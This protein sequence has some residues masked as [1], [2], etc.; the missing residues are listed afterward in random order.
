[1]SINTFTLHWH[2][3]IHL[4]ILLLLFFFWPNGMWDLS[5]LTGNW[6]PDPQQWNHRFLFRT[7]RE[8]PGSHWH[9]PHSRL[10]LPKYCYF[11]L[12]KRNYGT[13]QIQVWTLQTFPLWP[14]FTWWNSCRA[15]QLLA[16][17]LCRGATHSRHWAAAAG[18]SH[19]AAP[20]TS[21]SYLG[22]CQPELCRQ[23]EQDSAVR[24]AWPKISC[25]WKRQIN[26]TRMLYFSSVI[27]TSRILELFS[28]HGYILRKHTALDT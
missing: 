20:Q 24:A 6:T 10:Q 3:L 27:L 1:M 13:S 23:R 26:S 2:L 19:P 4:F 5:S 11:F 28:E 14:M 21:G 12:W 7:A 9:S 25:F 15:Q 8:F 22:G 16:P 17:A 18:S